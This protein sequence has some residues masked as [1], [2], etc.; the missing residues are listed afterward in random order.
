MWR[1]VVPKKRPVEGQRP[2]IPAANLL[3]SSVHAEASEAAA[4]LADPE[5]VTLAES[6]RRR[7]K[8]RF[9]CLFIKTETT[10]SSDCAK[11]DRS[12]HLDS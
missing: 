4:R 12:A 7:K 3:P 8:E 9:V 5:I 10:N 6:L 11:E 1:H 2:I